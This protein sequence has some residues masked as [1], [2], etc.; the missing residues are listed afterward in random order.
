MINDFGEPGAEFFCAAAENAWCRRNA[1]GPGEEPPEDPNDCW[2][3]ILASGLYPWG[4]RGMYD[5]PPTELRAGRVEFTKVDDHGHDYCVWH[6]V[7]DAGGY[8]YRSRTPTI[9]TTSAATKSVSTT[10]CR[11]L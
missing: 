3:T 7:G 9:P 2:F 11:W 6:Y 8:E 5:G 4:R 10:R 1:V